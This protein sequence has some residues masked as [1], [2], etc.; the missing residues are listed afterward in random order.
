MLTQLAHGDGVW[1]ALVAPG[2]VETAFWDDWA[3]GGPLEGP[4][5]TAE[6]VGRSV[7]WVWPE[8]PGVDVNT[9][10]VRPVGQAV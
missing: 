3:G 7:A 10:V 1:M 2:R 4:V 9:V 5:L 6:D 8:P